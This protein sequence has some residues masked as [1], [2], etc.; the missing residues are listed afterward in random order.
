MPDQEAAIILPGKFAT[1]TPKMKVE[2]PIRQDTGFSKTMSKGSLQKRFQIKT[3]QE[4]QD[5]G[6]EPAQCY[7]LITKE[8]GQGG[9]IKMS[10]AKPKHKL[11]T[12]SKER[13]AERS[14]D[15][16]Q[17][18]KLIRKEN[19]PQNAEDVRKLTINKPIQTIKS[20]VR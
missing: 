14:L 8:E 20:V 10:K 12:R 6:K 9:P 4:L 3:P 19:A 11:I 17:A 7:G 1:K 16:I 18:T 2:Q 5:T 15:Q 13:S